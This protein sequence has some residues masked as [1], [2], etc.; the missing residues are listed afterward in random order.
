MPR[1]CRDQR[2]FIYITENST[3]AVYRIGLDDVFGA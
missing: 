3:M 1:I 2:S